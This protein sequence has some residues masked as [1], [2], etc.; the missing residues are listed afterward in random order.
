MRAPRIMIAAPGSGSGKTLLTCAL[1][2]A[3]K[4]EEK[5]RQPLSVDRIISTRCSTKRCSGF[6]Q[7]IWIP[8]LPTRRRP[9]TC[10]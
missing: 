9:D 7:K 1:L 2:A 8:F 6:R 3:L 4:K 10:F 5:I